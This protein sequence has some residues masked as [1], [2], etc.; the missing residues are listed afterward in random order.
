MKVNPISE[1]DAAAPGL[2]KR[3]LYDFEVVTAVEK[4]SKGGNDMTELLNKVFDASGKSRLVNDYLV[5]SEGMAYK[6]RHFAAAT[7][8]LKQYEKG[9]VPAAD[10]VGKTGRCQLTIEKGKDGYPDKNK[11]Q[12]YVPTTGKLIASV[13]DKDLP[14]DEIPF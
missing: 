10:M 11:I 4:V 7:G 12:D 6:T 8:M 3:G 1:Q 13:A 9:D 14:D 5:E 2:W